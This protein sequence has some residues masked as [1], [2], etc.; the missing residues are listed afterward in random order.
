MNNTIQIYA[1]V[2][3]TITIILTGIGIVASIV[4]NRIVNRRR[5]TVDMILAEQTK[6]ELLEFRRTFLKMLLDGGWEAIVADGTRI[7]LEL[8]PIIS[9]LN[10]YEI[11]AIAIREG[12]IDERIYKTYWRDGVVRDWI[13][14]R[15]LVD[16]RRQATEIPTS[17]CEFESLARRWATPAELAKMG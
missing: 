9:T 6:P 17:W 5:T 3:Q 11:T 14:S 12:A 8:V 16:A 15:K 10:R 2:L 1:A 7:A 4:W 13:R